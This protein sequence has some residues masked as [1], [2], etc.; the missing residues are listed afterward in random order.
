MHKNPHISIFPATAHLVDTN[1]SPTNGPQAN[2]VPEQG[3]SRGVRKMVAP[4]ALR[5]LIAGGTVGLIVVGLMWYLL[6][7]HQ[8]SSAV[9]IN[10]VHG[11]NEATIQGRVYENDP[12]YAHK[13]VVLITIHAGD[14]LWDVSAYHRPPWADQAQWVAQVAA[15]NDI[16]PEAVFPGQIVAIPTY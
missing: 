11:Q 1:P 10:A 7:F 6:Q 2:A 4:G 9:A 13:G 15:F 5:R 14:S 3:A 8:V 16:R 12:A